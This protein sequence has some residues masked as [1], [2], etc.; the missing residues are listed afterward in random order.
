[1]LGRRRALWAASARQARHQAHAQHG[2]VPTRPEQEESEAARASAC[3]TCSRWRAQRPPWLLTARVQA[4][5]GCGAPDGC[6]WSGRG[7][8]LAVADPG[9][10]GGWAGARHASPLGDSARRA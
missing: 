1:M 5:C 2:P 3:T 4:A 8:T 6:S 10:G 9:G 7:A